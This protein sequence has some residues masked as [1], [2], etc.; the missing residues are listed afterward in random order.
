VSPIPIVALDVPT[1]LQALDL[2]RRL[3]PRAEWVK[4][5]LQLFCSEGPELVRALHGEGRRVF[6]DLKFH[7][8]PN[9]VA[10]AVESAAELGVEMLTLHASGGAAMLRAAREARGSAGP[11]LF[12]VTVLT[13]LDAKPEEVLRFAGTAADAGMDGVVASVHEADQIRRSI[14]SGLAILS[15]GIRL[16]GGTAH[17]QARIAT[18]AEAARAGVDFVVLGRAMTASDDPAACLEEVCS[19]FAATPG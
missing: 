19:V 4:V 15:P 6:L 11:K 18:A 8:I 16:A 5:G 9:T 10:R 13:S 17:D 2:L 1:R 3:G 14:G 12:A 7:D